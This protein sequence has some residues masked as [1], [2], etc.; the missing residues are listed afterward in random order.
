[1]QSEDSFVDRLV[2]DICNYIDDL[3]ANHSLQITVHL[4]DAA[5]LPCWYR[6]LPYNTHHNIYCLSIKESSDAWNHCIHCQER[7]RK[8][9]EENG[10]YVGICWAG[11]QEAIFPLRQADGKT[12]AF[13]SVGG[14][15]APRQVALP[16]IK[17]A[18]REF[19]LNYQNLQESYRSLKSSMPDMAILSRQIAPL[20]HMITLLIEHYLE[21]K[22]A[23]Q[24]VGKGVV[25]YE[26]VMTYI[27][28]N[29]T[30]KLTLW[31]LGEYCHCS[32]SCISHLFRQFGNE[33]FTQALTRIRVDAAKKYLEYTNQSVMEIAA[34]CGFD[35]P[36]YF[37]NVFHKE[38]G[39]SPTEW[40]QRHYQETQKQSQ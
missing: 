8:R 13:L 6:F 31:Q 39:V 17:R 22:D 29:F 18:S 10:N 38:T 14:Y 21:K 19:M 9:A 24:I 20:Q 32:Y 30:Q 26:R 37:S 5:V 2:G 15:A 16:R 40:R 25:Q 7:V 12:L 11:C 23:T 34:S 3:S 4:L 27:G 28:R 35:D 1:M 36:N 33:T